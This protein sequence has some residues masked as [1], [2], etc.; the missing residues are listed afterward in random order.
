M[1]E[2]VLVIEHVNEM[3]DRIIVDVCFWVAVRIVIV[4]ICVPVAGKVVF[5]CFLLINPVR[6]CFFFEYWQVLDHGKDH[7]AQKHKNEYKAKLFQR[8]A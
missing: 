7:T 3:T 1:G 4:L 2:G 5:L 8:E 6:W